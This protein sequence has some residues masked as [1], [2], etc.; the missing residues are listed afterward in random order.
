M[1]NNKIDGQKLF[2][3][4]EY[5]KTHYTD[6]QGNYD[7]NPYACGTHFGLAYMLHVCKKDNRRD[8]VE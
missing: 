1:D 2:K 8:G 7:P 6:P 4:E 3:A 5:L